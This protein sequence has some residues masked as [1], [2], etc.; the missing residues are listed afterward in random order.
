[1]NIRQV[2]RGL[3]AL[4]VLAMVGCKSLE[5]E[6]PNEPSSTI[7]TDP[8]VLETVAA[9]TM[10]SWFNNYAT[11]DQTLVLSVQSRGLSSSWNNGNMNY[12]GGIDIAPSDTASVPTAWSRA[13][14]PWTNDLSAAGRTSIE[15][16]WFGMYS[17]LSAANDALKAIRAG[18]IVIGDAERTKRAETIAQLMQAASLMYIA[19]NYDQGYVIDETTNLVTVQ[20]VPRRDVKV[21]ALAAFDAAIA[22]ANANVFETDPAWT[23]DAEVY[24]NE[25]IAKIANTMAAMLLAWYPRD[26][27]EAATASVVDWAQVE[28]Y[29]SNGMSSG[30]SAITLALIGDGCVAWCNAAMPWFTDWST[31]RVS[32]RLAH[33]LD[34]KTQMDPYALGVGSPQPSSPDRRMGD[35]SFGGADLI[36]VYD[37]VPAT[38]NAGTDFTYSFTAEI[39]RPD[40]GFYAQSNI[41]HARWDESGIQDTELQWAGYGYAPVIT[42]TVNDLIWAEALLR[43]GKA[44]AAALINRTR[45]TRG[46]LPQATEADP[47]G[48]P[49]DG[50][51]MA[52]NP[53]TAAPDDGVLAKDGTACTRWSKL[54]Y[55]ADI[56]LLQLGPAHFWHQRHLP[57]VQSTA[58]E[59]VGGCVPVDPCPNRQ[60]NGARFIQGLIPGTAREMPVPAKELAIK[61]EPFYTFG[62]A[63]PKGTEVP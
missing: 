38:A 36:P 61:A 44:G 37:N 31:G 25:D 60:T 34:P 19:L 59:R 63:T 1:M 46:G 11:L 6:N 24:T 55:E 53:K 14:R 3:G 17:T 45:V 22:L 50:P 57:V 15:V 35:G 9:G 39:M 7:L 51:C 20:R 49:A 43:Q 28:T 26:D 10:R 4:T 30:G 42:S 18:G 54:L 41:G 32:T 16:G 12:Y 33:F 8:N 40:R 52:D 48:T 27:T 5:I 58:W 21:A 62:G 47:I 13:L 56:E 23:N 2:G 29:A